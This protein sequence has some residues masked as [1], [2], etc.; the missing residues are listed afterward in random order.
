MKLSREF[1]NNLRNTVEAILP[2]AIRDSE[3]FSKLMMKVVL[4]RNYATFYRFKE[5]A[6]GLSQKEF[7]ELYRQ[8]YNAGGA[9]ERTTDL[10]VESVVAIRKAVVGET[11]LEV[12]CGGG[13]LLSQLQKKG[14]R[15][16]ATD[17][18]ISEPLRQKYQDVTFISAPME[19]LPF[20]DRSFDTVVTTHTI[21]HV[22][23]LCQSISEL[24]RVTKRRLIIVTPKQRP[25]RHTPD[26]HLHFFAYPESLLALMGPNLDNSCQVVGGDLFYV[27]NLGRK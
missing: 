19:S 12:G 3:W 11:I 6:M 9:I 13:Y 8:V 15:L 26:L 22:R 24:R 10:N 2:P 25:Y 5:T 7:V 18:L 17:I 27:E 16:S 23:D 4:G 20:P 1:T 21:E 14:T